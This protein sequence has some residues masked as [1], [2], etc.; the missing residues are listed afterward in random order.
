MDSYYNKRGQLH[1]DDGPARIWPDG[2]TEWWVEHKRHRLDGP[3]VIHPDGR[4]EW[5][6]N[7]ILADKLTVM[8]LTHSAE[9]EV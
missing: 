3:A 5:W 2:T 1:R 7:G 8:L 6:I 4:Q 9:I